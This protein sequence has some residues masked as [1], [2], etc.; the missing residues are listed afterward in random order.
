MEAHLS[1]TVENGLLDSLNFRPLGSS[2]NYVLETRTVRYF[3]EDSGT[4][5]PNVC[6]IRFRLVDQGSW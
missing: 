6:M 3:A 1:S 5:G 2:A 4:F